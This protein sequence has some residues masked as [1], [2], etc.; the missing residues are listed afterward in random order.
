MFDEFVSL[1]GD[2]LANQNDTTLGNINDTPG[3]PGSSNDTRLATGYS[4]AADVDLFSFNRGRYLMLEQQLFKKFRVIGGY[5]YEE[6]SADVSVNGTLR[7]RG[8]GANNPLAQVPSDG[9]YDDKRWLPSITLVYQ[10]DDYT[11]IRFA[12]S[13]TVAL[14]SAREVSPYASSSFSGSDIE[15]GNLG[16]EPSAVENFDLGFSRFNEAGDLFGLS[17]FRKVVQGRIERLNGLNIALN[18]GGDPENYSDYQIF[19]YDQNIGAPLFSWYNNPNESEIEGA[20]VEGRKNLGFLGEGLESF[21]VGGNVALIKGRVERFPIEIAA[22][23]AVGRPVSRERKLTDQPEFLANVDLSYENT[24]RGL[25][26]SL[27]Y[28]RFGEVLNSASLA[29]SYDIYTAEYGTFDL[30]ASKRFGK[31]FTLS[32]SVKNLTDSERETFY[33]VEGEPVTRDRYK[34]GRAF[35]ISGALDF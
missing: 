2:N 21:S 16:L 15:V 29:D 34:V 13:R 14:P 31:N 23:N 5:R 33:D 10:P 32:A 4:V 9:G 17:L 3:A 27:I 28:Y 22:K 35:S 8:A 20:E 11:N 24:E 7:L 6:N 1:G 26:V 19:A 12:Y 30:T 18:P 25:R